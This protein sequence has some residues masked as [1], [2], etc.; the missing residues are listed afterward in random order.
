MLIKL[1][2]LCIIL[3]S[4]RDLFAMVVQNRVKLI[5]IRLHMQRVAKQSNSDRASKCNI[6]TPHNNR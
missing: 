5:H 1:D 4:V 2:F 6:L 3:F